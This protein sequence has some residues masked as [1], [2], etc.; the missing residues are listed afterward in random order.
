MSHRNESFL[1]AAG[2]WESRQGF[3]HPAPFLNVHNIRVDS[4]NKR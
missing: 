3:V 2:G 4:D 1:G